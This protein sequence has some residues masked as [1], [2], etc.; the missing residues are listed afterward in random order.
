MAVEAKEKKQ[1]DFSSL[2][3]SIKFDNFYGMGGSFLIS[4]INQSKVFSKGWFDQLVS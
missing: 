4:P 2:V 3:D 1:I